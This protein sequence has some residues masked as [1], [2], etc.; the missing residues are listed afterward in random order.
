MEAGL[1]Q[2]P[3]ALSGEG[4]PQSEES[5]AKGQWAGASPSPPPEAAHQLCEAVA[6]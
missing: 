1:A 3:L 2:G 6:K 5:S 4:A